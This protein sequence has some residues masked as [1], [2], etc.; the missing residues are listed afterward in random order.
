MNT[1][2]LHKDPSINETVQQMQ[3]VKLLKLKL[4]SGL[5]ASHFKSIESTLFD[6]DILKHASGTI[7]TINELKYFRVNN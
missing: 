2:Y 4:Y 3:S 6:L 1:C 7:P 5:G